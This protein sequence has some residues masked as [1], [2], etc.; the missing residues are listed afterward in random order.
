MTLTN[1]LSG[2]RISISST[3]RAAIAAGR[4]LTKSGAALTSL[5]MS[6]RFG[7]RCDSKRREMPTGAY[8]Y[9]FGHPWRLAPV[10]KS[11]SQPAVPDRM[12]FV[13]NEL[14]LPRVEDA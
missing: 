4:G 9:A 14:R 5:E 12:H 2:R 7:V 3:E 1:D 10:A 11:I 6:L 13:G 8:T